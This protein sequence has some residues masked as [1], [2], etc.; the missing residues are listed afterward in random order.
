MRITLQMAF[1]DELS[2]NIWMR[3]LSN[4]LRINHMAHHFI[5]HDAGHFGIDYSYEESL[6][7]PTNGIRVQIHF[8]LSEQVI[9]DNNFPPFS[10][11]YIELLTDF[12]DVNPF[13]QK[14]FYLFSLFFCQYSH[15]DIIYWI[16]MQPRNISFTGFYKKA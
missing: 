8:L 7:D 13:F 1:C 10:W 5:E 9:L 4:I 2:I 14:F 15:K 12:R 3:G 6:H 11:R 16:T